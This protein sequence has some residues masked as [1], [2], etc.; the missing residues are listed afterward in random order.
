[1]D[2]RL[3]E[4]LCCPMTRVAVRSLTRGELEALNRA[5]AAGT[6]SNG[7]GRKLDR[8]ID[9]GLVTRDGKTVYR[10]EDDIPVMLADESIASDQVD[11][12][13]DV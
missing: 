7:A 12:F 11:G 6:V 1:M 13:P 9:A 3:L 10:I 5:I 2:K 4:I 8:A